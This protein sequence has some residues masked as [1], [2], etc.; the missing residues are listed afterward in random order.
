MRGDDKDVHV[1]Q[2]LENA[3]ASLYLFVTTALVFSLPES[4]TAAAGTLLS[5]RFA[6]RLM[7]QPGRHVV[8]NL[9]TFSAGA[10]E[11]VGATGRGHFLPCWVLVLCV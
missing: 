8:P 5:V 11:E 7:S 3:A 1:V 9:V 6:L 4:I 2:W 10:V